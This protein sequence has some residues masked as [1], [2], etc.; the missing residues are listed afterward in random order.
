METNII[1]RSSSGQI[2]YSNPTYEVWKPEMTQI[3]SETLYYSNPT[4][5]VWKLNTVVMAK[6]RIIEL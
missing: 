1:S 4:Y 5:E 2:Y 6:N 3:G